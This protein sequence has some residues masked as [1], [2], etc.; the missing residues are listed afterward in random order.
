MSLYKT[1]TAEQR[2]RGG[3]RHADHRDETLVAEG[4]F[5]EFDHG[6]HAIDGDIR[7]ELANR[8]TCRIRKRHRVAFTTYDHAHQPVWTGRVRNVELLA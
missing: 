8:G 4:A 6:P 5:H 2:G 1:N 7:I 3:E